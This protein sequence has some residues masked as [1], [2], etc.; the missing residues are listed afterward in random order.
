MKIM[1][2]SYNEAVL[3]AYDVAISTNRRIIVVNKT[4]DKEKFIKTLKKEKEKKGQSFEIKDFILSTVFTLEDFKAYKEI[5]FKD[6]N[7]ILFDIPSIYLYK[8]FKDVFISAIIVSSDTVTIRSYDGDTLSPLFFNIKNNISPSDKKEK[9]ICNCSTKDKECDC[10][11]DISASA[12]KNK[13]KANIID[14]EL[15]DSILNKLDAFS[16][17]R[18]LLY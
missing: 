6:Y 8:E 9:K 18:F 5:L 16:S 3:T 2:K 13:V 4:T 1:E 11:K 15:V 7:L 12:S 17:G 14:D 10:E